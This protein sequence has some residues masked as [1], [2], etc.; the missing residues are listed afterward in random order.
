MITNH[1]KK[2]AIIKHPLAFTIG[3]IMYLIIALATHHYF[4]NDIFVEIFLGL[5]A[6]S[7][8]YTTGPKYKLK[9]KKRTKILASMVLLAFF[10]YM[11]IFVTLDST[12]FYLA[13]IVI[14]LLL[15]VLIKL[16]FFDKE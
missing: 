14:V 3:T 1:S 12:S 2:A 4:G 16:F 9:I 8:I 15:Y 7:I 13:M 10:T 6:I 5:V 11:L